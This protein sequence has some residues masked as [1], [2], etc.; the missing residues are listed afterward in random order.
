MKSLRQE[1]SNG[2]MERF[3]IAEIAVNRGPQVFAIITEQALLMLAAN[4][5]QIGLAEPRIE[6]AFI[7]AV[8][9][10]IANQGGGE[11]SPG[12]RQQEQRKEPTQKNCEP[13]GHLENFL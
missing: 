9:R 11:E 10:G 13:L 4:P 6:F 2:P 12:K 1:L 3:G 5:L 7:D 8:T